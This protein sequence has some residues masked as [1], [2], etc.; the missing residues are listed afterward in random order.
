[1]SDSRLV[2]AGRAF[3]SRL[4][5]GTGKFS[6]NDVMRDA[7]AASGSEIVTVALRR[8]DL[9]GNG[10]A[11]ANI[12]DFID[13]EKYL[14][15]PNTSG[16]MN[17]EEAVRLAPN[18]PLLRISLAQV[19]IESNDPKVNKRAIAYL[20]DAMRTEDKETQGWH[21]LATAY[22]RDNQIGM[23]ALALAEEGLVAGKKKDAQQQALRAKA[24]L[25]KNSASYNRADNIHR[26]AEHIEDSGGGVANVH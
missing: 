3:H 18:S 26:E 13:P 20:N 11:F 25:P 19:Y 23:A 24:L 21:L 10:D 2:I 14:L 22:G 1:M 4:L 9:S 16:A 7:L 8:A 5:L 12:L 17:A 6:S 15:L